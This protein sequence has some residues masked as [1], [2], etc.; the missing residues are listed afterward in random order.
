M[1]WIESHQQLLRHPKT[2]RLARLLGVSIPTAIGHLHCFWW[3]GMDFAADGDLS[4]CDEIDIAGA[5]LWEGDEREFFEAMVRSGFI[6][7]DPV[8]I[9]DWEEYGGKLNRKRAAN[10]ERMKA[11]RAAHDGER[12]SHVQRT[13][14]ARASHVQRKRTGQDRTG[15]ERPSAGAR[16]DARDPQPEPASQKRRPRS[17]Q[18]PEGW[19]P[20]ESTLAWA[21]E[22]GWSAAAFEREFEKFTGH[23][24]AKATAYANWDQAL[25]NWLRRAEEYSAQK[26]VPIRANGAAAH[27]AFLDGILA[28]ANGESG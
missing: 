12:A 16:E 25:V 23:H 26:V 28:I 18:L 11:A 5:A 1:A 21:R 2:A 3:W 22:H 10:A 14:D 7:V 15:Q 17:T 6:D 27:D 13:T 20:G 24:V 19:Q 4:H 8:R 9:H